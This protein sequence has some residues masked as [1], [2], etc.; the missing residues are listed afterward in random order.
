[1]IPAQ[2]IPILDQAGCREIDHCLVLETDATK[3][4]LR[5]AEQLLKES[6]IGLVQTILR[7]WREQGSEML[8][9]IVPYLLNPGSTAEELNPAGQP[10]RVLFPE[11]CQAL[12]ATAEFAI[13]VTPAHQSSSP[14]P[15]II[16]VGICDGSVELGYGD[17]PLRWLFYLPESL[18]VIHVYETAAGI[19][20]SPQMRQFFIRANGAPGRGIY[21]FYPSLIPIQYMQKGLLAELYRP[22]WYNLKTTEPF[23]KME[24]FVD[25]FE[26][27]AGNSQGFFPNIRSSDGE[28]TIFDWDH[29]TVQFT[30]LQPNFSA[31]LKEQ[32]EVATE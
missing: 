30:T 10:M 31:W 4:D 14:A 20:L 15:Q 18:A 13:L 3:A 11:F 6:E 9:T 27:G 7:G 8:L 25:F 24:Q 2:W 29:E 17:E 23:E 28:H 26:D 22:F 5:Q 1:M 16:C 21:G 19:E 12:D 32:F